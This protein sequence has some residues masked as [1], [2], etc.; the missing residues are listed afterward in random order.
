MVGSIYDSPCYLSWNEDMSKLAKSE[1]LKLLSLKVFWYCKLYKPTT[2]ELFGGT[3]LIFHFM[4]EWKWSF[5]I[6]S[7]SRLQSRESFFKKLQKVAAEERY[8]IEWLLSLAYS[9]N[10]QESENMDASLMWHLAGRMSKIMFLVNC[11]HLHCLLVSSTF[12]FFP[13]FV[14]TIFSPAQQ[15]FMTPDNCLAVKEIMLS[16]YLLSS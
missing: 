9:C 13:F 14:F 11:N 6:S 7:K 8:G 2:A 1:L 12:L 5:S 15:V 16:T 4:N 10:I 3:A